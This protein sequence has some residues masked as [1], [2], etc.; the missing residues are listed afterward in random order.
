MYMH[1]TRLHPATIPKQ[2]SPIPFV[3]LV[4]WAAVT[5][6]AAGGGWGDAHLAVGEGPG[7]LPMATH[8]VWVSLLGAICLHDTCMHFPSR[9][10]GLGL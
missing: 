2:M 10:R 7:D 5:I 3:T 6:V 4:G 1:V 9:H 8:A